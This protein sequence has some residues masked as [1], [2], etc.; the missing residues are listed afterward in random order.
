M[1][2][3]FNIYSTAAYYSA[4]RVTELGNTKKIF[5]NFSCLGCQEGVESRDFKN[6]TFSVL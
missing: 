5:L 2:P 4:A 1:R 3:H 6:L